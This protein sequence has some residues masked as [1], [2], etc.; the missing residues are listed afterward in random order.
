MPGEFELAA[1]AV[2]KLKE[3]NVKNDKYP[4]EFISR[5]LNRLATEGNSFDRRHV[6]AAISKF[7][8]EKKLKVITEK[9]MQGNLVSFV[10]RT[11]LPTFLNH[12]QIKGKI[13]PYDG[14][15]DKIIADVKKS[16]LS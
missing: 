16:Y 1:D 15:I 6:T 7:K 11:E 3:E 12:Y 2:H 13:V 10:E 14:K 8:K 5:L 4:A 9:P